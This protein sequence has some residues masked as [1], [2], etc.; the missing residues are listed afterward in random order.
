MERMSCRGGACLAPA[1]V[2]ER[3]AAQRGAGR[4]IAVVEAIDRLSAL[5]RFVLARRRAYNPHPSMHEQ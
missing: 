4:V 5:Q 3:E 1:L 2:S